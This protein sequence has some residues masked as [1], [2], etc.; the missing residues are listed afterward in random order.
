MP[1]STTSKKTVRKS[2]KKPVVKKSPKRTSSAKSEPITNYNSAL[3]YLLDR[4]DIERIRPSR[5]DPDTFKLDRMTALMQALGNPHEGLR[6]VHIAGTN[7]KGSTVA[8]LTSA[9][10]ACGY[11]VGTYTSPHL[12]DV[13]ERVCINDQVISHSRFTETM[14]MI[15]GA[16]EKLPAKLGKPT[17]FE[18]MTVLAFLHFAEQVVDICVIEAGLG[19]RLDAT[20]IIKPDVSAITG[21][22]LDH[23]QFLGAT[24]PEIAREKSGI[25]KKDVPALTIEQDA[26]VKVAMR[27]VAEE[28]GAILEVIGEEIDFSLRFEASP[29]LGPHTRVGL[30]TDR[31]AYEHVPVP[32]QGEHQARNCGLVLAIIDKLAERGFDLP[33]SKILIGL[34][35]TTIMGRMEIVGDKPKFL[36]DGAH[37]PSAMRA[38]IRSI[39]AHVP[40]DSMVMIFG[41]AADKDVEALLDAAALGADKVIFTRAKSNPRAMDPKE[42]GKLFT[43]RSTKMCQVAETLDEAISIAARASARDDLICI[44]G[45]F[46]LVGEARKQMSS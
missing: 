38:L 23:T 36:L 41:C 45:S 25:F 28:T 27:E 18:L 44:T 26:D 12:T 22:A 24:L 33:E 3:R 21:I 40:Y 34:E 11:A 39:G 30:T 8:M 37:N 17:F 5:V 42:L 9:L 32:L 20:N 31:Y 6:M 4:V 15:A 16:V 1:R 10:R 46:Y 19:G 13:R 29:Q 2:A 43:E 35:Q 14:I 7:G